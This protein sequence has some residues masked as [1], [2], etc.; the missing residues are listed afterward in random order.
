MK[1]TF[2]ALAFSMVYFLN[3]A[4]YSLSSNIVTVTEPPSPHLLNHR[5]EAKS[6]PL[7]SA[8]IWKMMTGQ[9]IYPLIVTLV[10]KFAGKSL[11]L[12]DSSCG[13]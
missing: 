9:S 13:V 8:T 2:A 1:D 3:D 6:A 7:I 11:R 10:L 4:L 12:F 5:P